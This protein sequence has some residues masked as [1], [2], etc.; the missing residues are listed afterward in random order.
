M[1][2]MTDWILFCFVLFDLLEYIRVKGLI[3]EGFVMGKVGQLVLEAQLFAQDHYN[4]DR[5]E[6]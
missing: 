1:G 5:D 2:Y 4:M 6:F 3:R